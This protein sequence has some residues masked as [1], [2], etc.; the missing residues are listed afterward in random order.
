MLNV[1]RLNNNQ[2]HGMPVTSAV[3]APYSGTSKQTQIAN[4]HSIPDADPSMLSNTR[5]HTVRHTKYTT[6]RSKNSASFL[7]SPVLLSDFPFPSYLNSPYL[8]SQLNKEKI[9]HRDPRQTFQVTAHN[10]SRP[11]ADQHRLSLKARRR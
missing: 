9:V 6:R 11:S 10:T 8:A 1:P 3:T 4:T 5:R 7:L 2:S